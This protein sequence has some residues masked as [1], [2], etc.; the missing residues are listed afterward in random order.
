MNLIKFNLNQYFN[1]E[2]KIINLQT[3][4]LISLGL[5]FLILGLPSLYK[6][7]IIWSDGYALGD[8]LINYEDGGF[9]RR[10]LSG[11]LFIS[12]ARFSGIYVGKIVLAFI[13]LLYFI[14]VILFIKIGRKIKFDFTLI[15]FCCLPTVFLFPLNDFFAFGRKEIILFII[16]LFFIDAYYKRDIYSWKFI[17]ILSSLLIIATLFHELIVFYVPYLILI[18]LFK[19][20][21][22][23]KGSLIKIAVIGTSTFIPALLIFT[24]GKDI[25]EGNSWTIFKELGVA[26]NV[27]KGIFDWPKEGFGKGK[28]NAL[29]FAKERNY[30]MYAISYLI[31]LFA[32]MVTLFRK[33]IFQLP[34]YKITALHI[35][36]LILSF[37]LFFLTI[38]WG[39]WLNIHFMCLGF[40]L[41]LFFE[42]RNP[43]ES[44]TVKSILIH[45]FNLK[46]GIKLLLFL[47]LIFG[48]SM[49]HVEL[50]FKLGPNELLRSLRDLFW[51]IRHLN[52]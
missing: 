3:I 17:L 25:N 13:S 44:T 19:Y 27:M 29:S 48:F 43:S 10:G 4:I 20:L 36:L 7:I 22:E 26:E 8:W 49:Q 23:K 12:L 39:R 31:T 32:F 1:K 2:I 52:F 42:K 6:R 24:L 28:A 40:I 16:F 30:E 38:D 15:L 33:K 9:K 11:S 34:V 45:F 21:T 47:I 41:I 14:F 37:P 50:G 18:Y 46:N 5:I 35:A 51:S